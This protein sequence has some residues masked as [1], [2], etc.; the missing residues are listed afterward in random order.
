MKELIINQ[1][2]K[3]LDKKGLKFTIDDISNNLNISKK[4]IYRY[5]NNK[6]SLVKAVYKHIYLN[7]NKELTEITT[8][9]FNEEHLF[10]ILN[11]YS[12]ALFYKDDQVFNLNSLT[13]ELENYVND[14]LIKIWDL[15]YN[16]LNYT[17]KE[18]L[19]TIVDGSIKESFK[20]NNKKEV[21]NKL[22]ELLIGGWLD[23]IS[24]KCNSNNYCCYSNG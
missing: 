22:V 4:T 15:I 20:N 2:L 1:T 21:I 12:L 10:N 11:N 5:F 24:I 7:I 6:E 16:Y 19:R 3:L 13:K 14:E 9:D 8:G 18:S 17:Q 23:A